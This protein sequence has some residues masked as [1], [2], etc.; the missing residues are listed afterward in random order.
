MTP[1]LTRWSPESA[2]PAF[3]TSEATIRRRLKASHIKPGADGFYATREILTALRS[4]EADRIRESKARIEGWQLKLRKLKQLY[5]PTHVM[6]RG[7]E[8]LMKASVNV[9]ESSDLPERDRQ[10][11]TESLKELPRVV[12]TA[13]ASQTPLLK[14]LKRDQ[15]T[16][17]KDNE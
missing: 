2:A 11:I 16:E 12:D 14:A 15:T 1:E 3:G 7:L 9:I 10:D 17:E 5:K 13:L 8:A 6:R 4:A